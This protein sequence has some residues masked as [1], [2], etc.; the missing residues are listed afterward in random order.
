MAEKVKGGFGK[1]TFVLGIIAVIMALLPLLSAWFLLINWLLWIV[2]IVGVVLGVVGIVKNQQK[3][4][5]GT[6]LNVLA[7]ILYIVIGNSDFMAEKAAKDVSSTV[8]VAAD[9]SKNAYDA[10]DDYE[11]Y[12]W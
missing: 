9:M 2:A 11:D 10:Y 12:E 8:K 5:V 7:V 4:I 6:A 1:S 3:A